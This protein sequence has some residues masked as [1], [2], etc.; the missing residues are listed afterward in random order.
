MKILLIADVQQ[1][2]IN[3]HTK[4]IPGEIEKHVQNFKYDLIVATRFINKG[5]SLFQ[6]EL[7]FQ[8]M[9]MLSQDTKLV[10]SINDLADIVLMKSAYSSIT[11]DIDKLLKKNDMKEVYIAGLNTE[12]VILSTAFHLFDRDIKPK[13]L[14]SLC[15]SQSG[16]EIHKCAINILKKAIGSRNIL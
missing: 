8:N 15:A 3:E 4:H 16:E 11:P 10:D 6:S 9:T 7:D 14:S 1:G 2:F 13:V 5:D 12:T